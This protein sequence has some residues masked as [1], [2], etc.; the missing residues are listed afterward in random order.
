MVTTG[1]E[2]PI[3]NGIGSAA[4]A[5]AAPNASARPSAAAVVQKVSDRMLVLPGSALVVIE[6]SAVWRVRRPY[7][8]RGK[9]A[10]RP[11]DQAATL[12]QSFAKACNHKSQPS[13]SSPRSRTRKIFVG[14]QDQAQ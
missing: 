11:C 10:M 6:L 1:A 2:M 3:L 9:S 14:R 4:R 13:P 5:V 7:Q 12:D 8:S